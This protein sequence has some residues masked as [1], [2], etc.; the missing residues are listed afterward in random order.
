[1]LYSQNTFDL[2]SRFVA[3][4]FLRSI[5]PQRRDAIRSLQVSQSNNTD[6]HDIPQSFKYRPAVKKFLADSHS[7]WDYVNRM[8]NLRILR[9]K[10]KPSNV[11][12]LPISG[13]VG[14]WE[15]EFRAQLS[16]ISLKLDVFD[17]NIPWDR[18]RG[19]GLGDDEE[20]SPFRISRPTTDMENNVARVAAW[21]TRCCAG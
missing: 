7:L 11:Y 21:S 13:I 2:P 3:L 9:V 20:S 19:A 18:P 10:L 1:M 5:L 14:P 8:E 15:M 6:L 4:T 17:V 16:T 12:L